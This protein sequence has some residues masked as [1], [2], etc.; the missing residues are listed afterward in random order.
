MHAIFECRRRATGFAIA[1]S[2][3]SLSLV[4]L[5][6]F[7]QQEIF[8]CHL[9]VHAA[10]SAEGRV[11][12]QRYECNQPA[13][14]DLNLLLPWQP[15]IKSKISHRFVSSQVE[16][17]VLALS[18]HYWNRLFVLTLLGLR[19]HREPRK[20]LLL[21]RWHC[22]ISLW[23]HGMNFHRR[24]QH[25][26]ARSNAAW[27]KHWP[28]GT[29]DISLRVHNIIY[30]DNNVN[31]SQLFSRC[32]VHAVAPRRY[33]CPIAPLQILRACGCLFNIYTHIK[34]I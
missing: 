21:T 1:E 34:E 24:W 15:N 11:T 20:C 28:R 14:F 23:Q 27:L 5:P 7:G 16:D 26:K 4:A 9:E 12:P 32:R 31:L 22:G 2:D 29:F 33:A 10:T 19:H 30:L 3:P 6:I 25:L 17:K 18:C 13:C 8:A